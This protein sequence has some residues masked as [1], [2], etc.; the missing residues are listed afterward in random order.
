MTMIDGRIARIRAQL[1][2][3]NWDAIVL[4]NTHDVVYATGYSSIM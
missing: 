3:E 4:T 1:E 2:R